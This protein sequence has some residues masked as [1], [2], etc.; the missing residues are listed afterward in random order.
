MNRIQKIII[1]V[2]LALILLS[3]LFPAYEQG[4]GAY[5]FK[6]YLGY[7]LVFSPPISANIIVSRYLIQ[8]VT[9]SFLTIGLVFLFADL[10]KDK[11]GK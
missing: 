1:G 8:I 2:G 11:N 10:K 4:Y 9:I 6:E 5:G 7:Y 3:G